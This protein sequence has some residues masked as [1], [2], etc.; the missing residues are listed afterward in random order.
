MRDSDFP[1]DASRQALEVI[2]VRIAEH[3]QQITEALSLSHANEKTLRKLAGTSLNDIESLLPFLGFILRSTNIRNGF[4]AYFPLQRLCQKVL[5]DDVSLLLSSE[6]KYSPYI[7]N[8]HNPSVSLLRD[9]VM[10]GLPA[11]ESA[12]PLILPLAGHELGHAIWAHKG[13]NKDVEF[14]SRKF[15]EGYFTKT[16]SECQIHFAP[17]SLPDFFEKPSPLFLEAV[18]WANMQLQEIFSDYVG[19]RIFGKAYLNAFAYLLSP[20]KE[21][22]RSPAYPSTSDR[23]NFQVEAAKAFGAILD[24]HY[25]DEYSKHFDNRQPVAWKSE[26]EKILLDA[27]ETAVQSSVENIQ[28]LADRIVEEAGIE[29]PDES[30]GCHLA[31]HMYSY[32]APC[33]G[34]QS[35]AEIT[36]AGWKIYNHLEEWQV[37]GDKM[38]LLRELL[39]KSFEIHEVETRISNANRFRDNSGHAE[40]SGPR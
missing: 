31:Q 29:T 26:R 8:T 40:E 12:N 37:E 38:Q 32:L 4:E 39:L 14:V 7:Y 3:K 10:V 35:I 18:Q 27:A 5:G 6:W 25:V 24:N 15:V 11:H 28:N 22:R 30:S 34:A 36:N 9:F 33:S 1:Y 2:G 16:W 20:N 19:I 13:L 17:Q 23:I 21:R